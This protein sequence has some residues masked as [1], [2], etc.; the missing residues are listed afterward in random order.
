[1]SRPR[2]TKQ[3]QLILEVLRGT[4]AHPTADWVYQQVRAVLPNVSLGT[5]YRN[6]GVLKE[7]EL[8]QEVRYPG[9][10]ARFDGNPEPHYHFFC[11]N[12]DRI[13]DVPLP[14]CRD[15]EEAFRQKLPEYEVMGHNTEFFGLCPDCKDLA[16]RREQ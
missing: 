1:M 14:F 9:S 2:N 8:I 13:E 16:E 11:L 3:R 10:Q 5:I 4:T 15:A 6:L 7:Q 12:C